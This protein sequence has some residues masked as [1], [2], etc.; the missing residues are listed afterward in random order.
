M[1]KKFDIVALGELLIDFTSN[2]NSEAG[3]TLFEANPGGAPCNMLAMSAKLGKRTAFIG[4]VGKDMF[5]NL[6]KE[7]ASQAGINMDNLVFDDQVNTTLV[8]VQTAPDGDRSFSFF[9]NPGAD[10]M[11][12]ADEIDHDKITSSRAFHFGTLSLTNEPAKNAT[13]SAVRTA[14]DNNLI[15][16]FDPN[17]RPALWADMKDAKAQMTWGAGKCHIM[18]LA[19]EELEFMMD[20]A[21]QDKGVDMLTSKN[22]NIKVVFVTDGANGSTCYIGNR[23]IF[24]PAFKINA[25]DTTGA[26]DT[27]FG[28]CVSYILDHGTALE[29]EQMKEMLTFANASAA[30]V[31]TRKGALLSMP[32]KEEVENLAHK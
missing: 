31:A 19:V 32:T 18:K 12:R 8:F 13:I 2:G 5:G 28:A 15:I 26:G 14:S 1:D 21:D 25:I 30:I 10:T 20:E 23:K 6:L 27:F 29:E 17:L 16:T 22:P 9:R 4:K 3:N 24:V 11:I 7:K